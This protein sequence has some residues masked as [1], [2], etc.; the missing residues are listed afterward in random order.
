MYNL[1]KR[2]KELT[3]WYRSEHDRI[4][5]EQSDLLEQSEDLERRYEKLMAGLLRENQF[6]NRK[7]K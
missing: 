2:I 6:T 4:H 3:E 7:E 1:E 5:S